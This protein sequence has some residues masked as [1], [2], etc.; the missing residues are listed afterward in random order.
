MTEAFK[1]RMRGNCT[2][3]G[4]LGLDPKHPE[5]PCIACS[6]EHVEEFGECVGVVS[7]PTDYNNVPS[8]HVDYDPNKV[9]PELDV[10]WEPSGLRYAYAATSL[11]SA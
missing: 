1:V 10:R 4:H 3:D 5:D 6:T 11:R 2:P 8:G 7:G 9:G